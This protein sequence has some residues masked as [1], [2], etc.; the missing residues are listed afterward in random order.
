MVHQDTQRSSTKGGNLVTVWDWCSMPIARRLI[1]LSNYSAIGLV[2]L[3]SFFCLCSTTVTVRAWVL[4]SHHQSTSANI[5]QLE[6]EAQTDYYSGKYPQ[7]IPLL[8]QLLKEYPMNP[9]LLTMLGIS[10]NEVSNFTTA[11][12]FLKRALNI[13]HKNITALIGIGLAFQK[14][15][16]SSAASIYFE[17][18]IKHNMRYFAQALANLDKAVA[19]N[20]HDRDAV[21]IK[22]LLTQILR[23]YYNKQQTTTA[24]T[25]KNDIHIGH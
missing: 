12:S 8:N 19:I 4:T 25:M 3:F 11:I 10:E 15:E 18:A 5:S 23:W 6:K 2:I 7:A 16:N 22:N 24:A 9:K 20:P 17:E 1:S 13:G 14:L 21:N